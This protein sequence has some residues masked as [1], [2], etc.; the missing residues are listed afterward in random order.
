MIAGYKQLILRAHAR[1]LK[2]FGGTL[3]PFENENFV[4]GAY[5]PEGDA[6]RQ[7]VNAWIRGSSMFDAVIDFEKAIRD[8]SHPTS[9]LPMW[10]S[11]DHLHP[12][13]VGYLHLGDSIDLSLFK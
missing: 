11:G 4:Q 6:K 1:G 7:A 10:D 2:I 5:T 13:D 8:P 12:G 3:L 9:M